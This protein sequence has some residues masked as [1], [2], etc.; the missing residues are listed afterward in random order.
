MSVSQLKSEKPLLGVPITV[1]ESCAVKGNENVDYV[2]G[3][4]WALLKAPCAHTGMKLTAGVLEYKDNRAS[5]NGDA[6]DLM[7]QAGAIPIAVTSTPYYNAWIET[8][9]KIIGYT[10]N[11]YDQRKAVGG[12][13]G[14]EVRRPI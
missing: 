13:S 12:S 8:D 11:P 7:I 9:N 4:F 6:V 3:L 1:K 14:G 5:Y 10:K 2:G